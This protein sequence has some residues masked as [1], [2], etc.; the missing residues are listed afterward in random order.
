MFVH[1]FFAVFTL[2]AGAFYLG[3]GTDSAAGG[4]ANGPTGATCKAASDCYVGVDPTT[5]SGSIAC[6][7]VTNGYCTHGC[8]TD[9]DC[10]SVKGE[11]AGGRPEVCSP[12]ES[13]GKMVCL[14]SCESTDVGS[15]DPNA[16]CGQFANAAFT[17]R[18]SGGGSKNRKI[19]SP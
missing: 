13:I 18:S 9:A 17:C 1:R 4:G 12:F 5:L 14:L 11:C 10:C 19:C 16:Y 3:C 8:A 15:E 7:S 6:L 2:F